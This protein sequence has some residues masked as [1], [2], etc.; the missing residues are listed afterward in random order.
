MDKFTGELNE[1]LA[2]Y[3]DLPEFTITVRPRLEIQT[4][5]EPVTKL[6]APPVSSLGNLSVSDVAKIVDEV[7]VDP[8]LPPLPDFNKI[9]ELTDKMV[10]GQ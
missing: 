10:E 2:K 3:P 4:K 9:K 1:L 8:E 5:R 6:Y 7:I